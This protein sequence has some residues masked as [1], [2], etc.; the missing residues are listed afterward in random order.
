M[1]EWCRMQRRSKSG[2]TRKRERTSSRLLRKLRM[3][4][5][6]LLS[7]KLSI[8]WKVCLR[9]RWHRREPTWT[10][11][12]RMRTSALLVRREKEKRP[13]SRI[14]KSLTSLRSPWL[15]I[16]RNFRPTA[17]FSDVSETKKRRTWNIDIMHLEMYYKKGLV[18]T[19]NYWSYKCFH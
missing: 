10:S 7:N 1:R 8:A 19:N 16:T 5:A 9:T 4:D 11:R 6:M 17:R 3:K 2:L 15:T 18:Q 14:K 13:G 12:S